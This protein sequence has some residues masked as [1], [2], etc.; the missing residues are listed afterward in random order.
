[1]A[2]NDIRKIFNMP[3]H[4]E[5]AYYYYTEIQ[6]TI[7]TMTVIQKTK[8]NKCFRGYGKRSPNIMLLRILMCHAYILLGISTSAIHTLLLEM[9]TRVNHTLLWKMQRSVTAMDFIVYNKGG[10]LL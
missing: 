3:R 10:E 8:N 1:M 6:F 9:S 4:I 5:E 7:V 2:N